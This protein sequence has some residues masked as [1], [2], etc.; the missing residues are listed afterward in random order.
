[1]W[2]KATTCI[3]GMSIGGFLGGAIPGKC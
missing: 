3:A 2:A 1:D